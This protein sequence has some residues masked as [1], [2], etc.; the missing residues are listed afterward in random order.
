MREPTLQE[1][2]AA[3]TGQVDVERSTSMAYYCVVGNIAICVRGDT[4]QAWELTDDVTVARVT[5]SIQAGPEE[6][7]VLFAGLMAMGD[8]RY[9]LISVPDGEEEGDSHD[10]QSAPFGRPYIFRLSKT[11]FQVLVRKGQRGP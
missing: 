6:C 1:L 9:A 2:R 4:A 10:Q 8:A 11:E 5:Q 7:D 3:A